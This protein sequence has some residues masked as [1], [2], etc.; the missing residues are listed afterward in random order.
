MNKLSG[1]LAVGLTTLAMQ[2]ALAAPVVVSEYPWGYDVATNMDAVFGAGNYSYYTSYAS[3]P[4]ATVFS[5]ANNFVY[6]EGGDTTVGSL[7]N[8]L[9]A[10]S[11]DVLSWV[12]GG[13][14]L[15][16][17]AAGND[18]YD[19]TLNGVTIQLT[20]RYSHLNDCGTLTS[21]G[22]AAFTFYPTPTSQCGSS[23]AH[24]ETLGNGLTTF[25]TGDTTAAPILAGAAY[26][27]GYIMYS[28]LTVSM[29]HYDG[30]DSLANNVL[31]FTAGDHVAAAPAPGALALVGLGLFGLGALRRRAK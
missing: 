29:F 26:G 11:G 16:L 8:Y 30:G 20:P 7:F 28:G 24:A 19:I 25:M 21:E 22:I 23:I 2:S 31:A 15:L 1:F 13:G 10:N 14:R 6:L 3:L 4:T 27:A 12:A 17:Q 9:A 5:A 18:D